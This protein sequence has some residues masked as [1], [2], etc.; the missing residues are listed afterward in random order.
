MSFSLYVVGIMLMGI[1]CIFLFNP[2]LQK[3]LWE[4]FYGPILKSEV[5]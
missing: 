3:T 4:I 1:K 2:D 5:P